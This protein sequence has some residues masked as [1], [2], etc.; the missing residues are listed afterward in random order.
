MLM[1]SAPQ[2]SSAPWTPPAPEVPRGLNEAKSKTV[3][4]RVGGWTQSPTPL[5]RALVQGREGSLQ[6]T[7]NHNWPWILVTFLTF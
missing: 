1:G 6:G 3:V 2:G 5:P 4:P 7:M